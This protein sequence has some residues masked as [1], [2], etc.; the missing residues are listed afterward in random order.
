MQQLIKNAASKDRLEKI[1][2][3]GLSLLTNKNRKMAK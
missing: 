1:V 2:K 3:E